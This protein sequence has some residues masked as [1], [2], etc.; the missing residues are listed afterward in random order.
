ME[1]RGAVLA[2]TGNVGKSEN[3]DVLIQIWGLPKARKNKGKPEAKDPRDWE[4]KTKISIFRASRKS[5]VSKCFPRP[6]FCVY[7]ALTARLQ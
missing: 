5:S 7:C 3:R 1:R 4:V 2:V 6:L